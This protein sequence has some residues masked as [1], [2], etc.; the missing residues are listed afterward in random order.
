MN[1]QLQELLKRVYEEG[2]AKAQAE[3]EAILTGAK[4]KADSILED[5]GKQ[6]EAIVAE[7][8][9]KA[10]E[11]QKNSTSDIKLASQHSISTLKN[12]IT[13]IILQSVYDKDVKAAFNDTE[14]IK[15][16]IVEVLEGW[17]AGN[18]TGNL[19]ISESLQSKLDDHFL[20]SIKA[21]LGNKL[22]IE[23]SPQMK[24]GFTI[25]PADGTYKL[26]FT[27]ED[28][29]NLFKSFVRPRTQAL[30]FNS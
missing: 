21:I 20:G 30:L 14:F 3:A 15:K 29:I 25:S 19:V 22:N 11:L 16:V 8:Q 7:A 28:F 2:V 5:A 4:S 24:Q 26:S 6:A 13:D 17:K 12:K 1:D 23:F 27:E 18:S 10:D 9:K